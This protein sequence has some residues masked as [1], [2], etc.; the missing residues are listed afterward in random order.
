MKEKN[1]FL[2]MVIGVDMVFFLSLPLT[3]GAQGIEPCEVWDPAT[4]LGLVTT[5]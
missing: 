5:F 1:T 3:H 4:Y 2:W